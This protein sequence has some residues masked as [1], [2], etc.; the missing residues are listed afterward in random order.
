MEKTLEE[1]NKIYDVRN[2]IF[3]LRFKAIGLGTL[4][5]MLIEVENYYHEELERET[6][7]FVLMSEDFSAYEYKE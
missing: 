5:S 4:Y 7:K 3:R 6:E 1:L 2:L